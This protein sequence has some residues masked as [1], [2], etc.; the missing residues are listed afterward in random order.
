MEAKR[1][2]VDLAAFGVYL[3]DQ[4]MADGK[5]RLM[6]LDMEDRGDPTQLRE[7]GFVPV[8]GSP[9]YDKGIYYLATEDQRLRPKAL[10]TAFGLAE[11]PLVEVEPAE[12]E[13]VF[14]ERM[15]AKFGANLNAV[16]H[17]SRPLGQNRAGQYVFEAP[18]GRFIRVA[19]DNAVA[20]GSQQA[21][22][23]GRS[24]FLRAQD[25]SELR[26]CADGF[27][28]TV[29]QGGKTNWADLARFGKTV[30]GGDPNDEQLHRLQEA[31]E[32]SAYRR[33]A[34]IA[35]EPDEAAF[36]SAVDFYYGLPTA[37]MRTSESVFLQQYSTPLPMS[38][39]AQRLL[40]GGDET[41][42][43]SVI[44]PTAGNGGLLNLLPEGMDVFAV[45]LDAKRLAALQEAGIQARIGDATEFRFRT[46]APGLEGG[47]DYVIANP[48]FGAMDKAQRFDKLERVRKLDHYIP[49]RALESRKDQGRMVLIF[50]A[51]S[52]QSDGT[53]KGSTTAF[54]NYLFDHYEVH[55]LTEVD[56]RL[57]SRHGAGF[58]VRMMVVGDRRAEPVQMDVPERLSVITDY[59]TLWQWATHV[60]EQY[61][62]RRADARLDAAVVAK[63]EPVFGAGSSERL[64][65]STA[66][67]TMLGATRAAV[68]AE[69]ASVGAAAY[70]R[71]ELDA[72]GDVLAVGQSKGAPLPAERAEEVR[73]QANRIKVALFGFTD[74]EGRVVRSAMLA[75]SAL[76][77]AQEAVERIAQGAVAS[78]EA[79]LQ[80]SRLW[81]HALQSV[82]R[83]RAAVDGDAGTFGVPGAKAPWEMTRKEW[84][85]EMSATD[86]SS[87]GV[88]TRSAGSEMA[89]SMGRREFLRYGVTDWARDRLAAATRE[90]I[91]LTADEL[92]EVTDR[93]NTPV[94]HRDVIDKALGEGRAV[95]A[96]VLADYPDLSGPGAR[97]VNQFQTPYQ[98]A[99]RVGEASAMVPINMAGATYAALNA[100]ESKFGRVD[101][102]VADKL[103]Y[104][105]A[106]LARYFSP[107]QV[108]AI[109]LGIKAVEE[110][111]GIINAD[112]TG[113]GK[114]R[115]V[116]AMLRYAKLNGKLPVFLTIK[117]ELFT[118]LHRDVGDIGS[119]GLFKKLFIFNDGE[120]VKRF[121]TENEVLYR[122]T[123][124]AERKAAIEA[125][126]VDPDTDMVLATYSQF[127]RAAHKNPKAKLLTDIVA[128]GG[129]LVLDEAHVASGASNLAATVGEAVANSDAVLYASATPLKGVSNFSIYSRIFPQSVD[130]G[131]LADTL[132]AGGEALQEAISS[133]MARDGV[134]IRR[135][136]DFSK[137]TFHTRNPS[138]ERRERNVMLANELSEIVAGLSY[139]AGDVAKVVA[140]LNKGF[141]SDWEEIPERD[142]T[143]RRM[144]ASSMNFGSRLYS[145]NR[146]FLLGVKIEDSVEASL[147]AL[148]EGRKP[149]LAVENTGE[150]LL[151]QVIA[152]RAGVDVLEA[153]LAELDEQG[154]ASPEDK[155]RRVEL[156]AGINDA[157]RNVVLDEPPQ[158]R[159]LLES[160]LDRVGVIKTQGRY[161]DVTRSEPE[162]EEYQ[163]EQERL[164]EKIRAFPDLPLTPI[165]I[166]KRELQRRGH[167]VAEVSGR[168]ASIAPNE[169]DGDRWDV[170]FHPKTDAV[171][172]VAGFQ[173][174]RYDAIVI[175]RSGSTGISLHATDRFE[176]SDVRQ[177]EFICVQ[178]AANVSDFLQW[179]GRANR[180]DQVVPPVIT[181]LE[182]GLPA[183]LRLTMMHNAKLRKLSA[184]TTSNR[185]NA[186]LEGEDAD[187]LNDL[188]DRIALEWLTENPDVAGEL[189][190]TLPSSDE[191]DETRLTQDAP[192]INRLMGRLMMVSVP[193]Q[194]DILRALN[195]RFA[196]KLEELE[197][198]GENPFKVDVY[199]W[200]A[201]AVK[202]EELQSGVIRTTAS[203]FD[204]PVKMVTLRYEEQ[205][206]PI[207]SDKL[208]EMVGAGQARYVANPLTDERGSIRPF[209]DLL[210]E[211][212]S[213]WVRSQLPAKLRD[214]D[215]PL[216]TVL[217]GEDAPPGA[218][219]AAERAKWLLLNLSS[220][221][222]GQ[223]LP[224]DDPFRGERRGI[225]TS[226]EFPDEEEDFFLL[227]KYR[228][229]VV[230]PGEAVVREITLA[231]TRA[232]DKTLYTGAI[233]VADRASQ[234]TYVHRMIDEALA[235]FDS[236]PD[237][238]VVRTQ[239]VLQ[240]NI[241]R[242]CE[243]ASSQRLG[244]PVLYTDNEG[245]RQRA[246]LIKERISP[247]TVKALPVALEAQDMADYLDEHLRL[248]KGALKI[249]NGA[250]K[251]MAYG[252]GILL[253]VLP[254]RPMATLVI[255]GTKAKAGR[256]MTDGAIFDIGQKTEAGSLRLHLAGSKAFMRADVN[257]SDVPELLNR[258]QRN[259]HVSRFYVAQPDHD[260]I[261]TLKARFQHAQ[262][263]P[264]EAASG[265]EP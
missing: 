228:A 229:R 93:L 56:G 196:D 227:S 163:E 25:D 34:T 224:W 52:A 39:I 169:L 252:D 131:S 217:A 201:T 88:V 167:P 250:V 154:G 215:V 118:D 10:A 128:N 133:N 204:E 148:R 31:I 173:N 240:G 77:D 126:A 61:P 18:F 90:E 82:G 23:L 119:Q 190:I 17:R 12:V 141:R 78:D 19:K 261:K 132:R 62:D 70:V 232:Q 200:N 97:S 211:R 246:V 150:S 79:R 107:E 73:Q 27:L 176:D 103:Q 85:A 108:D 170:L 263:R 75:G 111:R 171:A 110:G 72:L 50:G 231:T 257:R 21:A 124:P 249:Y 239:H 159:E 149:I 3:G 209:R 212:Q 191:F 63:A 60:I 22:K 112:Q 248:G 9:R 45:E 185:D 242:A 202:E 122:A 66:D 138:D 89:R 13:Q 59:D 213:D 99:S 165:D 69:I 84:Q 4:V 155:A 189:D 219:N 125:G 245:N 194:E 129:M 48:P 203:T 8:S 40:V 106:E 49:L 64:K 198:R 95:P 156:V 256:L 186:N 44:E 205:V 87:I 238:A 96:V 180:K 53:V 83:A 33:F 153:E 115:F 264:A 208:L 162:S 210:V 6:V 188:G 233:N 226:V 174:G 76:S 222:P 43:K 181:S 86:Q 207:R 216:S 144:Q 65:A 46:I 253:E 81:D 98:S 57:Y 259:E 223:T 152:R 140:D 143:G 265:P 91:K 221:K 41:A 11:C 16:T 101:A 247:E 192:Y 121:G 157:M 197:Q 104:D 20:E 206:F 177:R 47:F 113:L 35:T 29:R 105:G 147:D 199:E 151:R 130:L 14:R 117:P 137:L 235:E 178:R 7:I 51:D 241:F 243:L 136:H 184:N 55:G 24:A 175:T 168:T 80:Q 220:F 145:L 260:I 109:G 71:R 236:V 38:V 100:L 58:N 225:I 127:M 42:G 123:T 37:R 193:R 28:W 30:F 32:A 120:S 182:S 230:F 218:K 234:P 172:Q 74:P 254:H 15:A 244:Y 92:E 214:S 166:I 67:E 2:W 262:E 187:L 179:L 94:D 158:F 139:L 142:R 5:R 54:L 146:Q 255:P 1:R 135:E 161:G 237:G 116:A 195:Q 68:D 251:D 258:L 114:G 164:R 102:Y 134:L 183:E 26:A 160:M 36:K